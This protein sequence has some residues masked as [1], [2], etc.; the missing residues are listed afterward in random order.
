MKSKSYTAI[1]IAKYISA[2]LVVYIHT[3]PLADIS[4]DLNMIVLQAVCR[5][6][7]PFFFTV[8]FCGS[9]T[10]ASRTRI[11]SDAES[12]AVPLLRRFALMRA[13]SMRGEKG[14]T[15]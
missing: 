7:V 2:L 8:S 1:D 11:C 9:I 12:P 10:S 13:I 6:A 4:A 3:F 14:F 5:I 15:I